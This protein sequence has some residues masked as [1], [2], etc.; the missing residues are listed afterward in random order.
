VQEA[1]EL[2]KR[3]AA[4]PAY[5]VG[6][7]QG[8]LSTGFVEAIYKVF[9]DPPEAMMVKQSGFAGGEIQNQFPDLEYGVDYDF[10]GFPGAQG[11]QG[12]SD[13]MMAF[14]DSPAVQALV[15]YLSSEMGG[16][17]WAAAGFDLTPNL[18]GQGAYDDP[19]LQKKGDI[20]YGAAGFTPDIGDTIPGG[21]GSAEWAAIV[22]YLNG[23]DLDALLE[24]VADVQAE[25]TSP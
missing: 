7:L 2:Y 11:V 1:Y 5:T 14:S 6:G 13:W 25:A 3:W 8:T 18:G 9:A 12:G 17:N 22:G 24:D 20:F 16:A 21:F 4:D 10:F 19:A 23:G 15:A